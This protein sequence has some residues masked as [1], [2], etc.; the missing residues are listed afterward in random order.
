MSEEQLKAFIE[1]VQGDTSLQEKLRT[2]ADSDEVLAIAKEDGFSFS[3][4]DLKNANIELSEEEL[5]SVA[6]GTNTYFCTAGK[7]GWC[8]YPKGCWVK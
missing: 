3:A 6:G 5:E 4:E 7:G 2:A 1:K 8:T